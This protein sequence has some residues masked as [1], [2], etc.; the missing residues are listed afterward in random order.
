MNLSFTIRKL[1]FATHFHISVFRLGFYL[2]GEG[3]F[4]QVPEL[5]AL[6]THLCVTWDSRSGAAA[7][8]M[9]GRKSL[10][11]IYKKGHAIRS[12]GKVIIG[13]DPDRYM[14]DFDANQ[15]YVGEISDISMWD[16]VLPASTIQD[17]YSGK[18]VSRGNVFDWE[19]AELRIN[20]EVNIITSDM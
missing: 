16:S 8:F 17:M 7:L 5:G 3:V 6:E 19:T 9:N 20:G 2:S 4:F 11:K 15:S 1:C 14:G 10:T 12:G 13:Q 18:R